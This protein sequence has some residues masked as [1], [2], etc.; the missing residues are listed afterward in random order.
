MR[1]STV[2]I[3]QYRCEQCEIT[4]ERT[5]TISE[6]EVA[7]PKCPK[8]GSKKVSVVPGPVYVVTIK[9]ELRAHRIAARASWGR[10]SP[11]RH[12]LAHYILSLC[13]WYRSLFTDCFGTLGDFYFQYAVVEVSFNLVL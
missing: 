10:R 7:K 5:K 6:R 11:R 13:N 1:R 9:K 12:P 8:C 4:F 3:Y 2:P